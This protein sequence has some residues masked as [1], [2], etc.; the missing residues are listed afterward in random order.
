MLF[1]LS[2]LLSEVITHKLL[3]QNN[4]LNFVFKCFQAGRE[5]E[6]GEGGKGVN[7]KKLPSVFFFFSFCL[8]FFVSLR[9]MEN[10]QMSVFDMLI[11]FLH[12]SHMKGRESHAFGEN[13]KRTFCR[14]CPV[15]A[16]ICSWRVILDPVN[17]TALQQCCSLV[18]TYMV[19]QKR[20]NH[21]NQGDFS[22]TSSTQSFSWMDWCEV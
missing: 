21:L 13:Q 18:R 8:H 3:C 20:L 16:W 15:M 17:N 14:L 22:F 1:S 9:L 6:R 2:P 12:S 5:A 19:R 7:I 10:S 11:F 4:S